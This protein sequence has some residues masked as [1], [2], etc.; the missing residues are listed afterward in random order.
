MK[1]L[2]SDDIRTLHMQLVQ[3]RMQLLDE[4]QTAE[5]DIKAAQEALEGEVRSGSDVS[6]LTRIE[7]LRRSE[8]DIDKRQLMAVEE[9]ERR[10]HAGQYGVCI[11]CGKVIASDRMFALPTAA[12]CT[13]CEDRLFSKLV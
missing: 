6:E 9:A 8:I 7:E 13:V 11:D 10:M 4:I 1:H 3:I 12:R 5:A 2:S